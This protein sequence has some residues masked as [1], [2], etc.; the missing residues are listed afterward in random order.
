[1][2]PNRI[3]SAGTAADRSTQPKLQRPAKLLPNPML[4]AVVFGKLRPIPF[5]MPM[6]QAI[7][8]GRKT[9]TR[10]TKGFAGVTNIYGMSEDKT[11]VIADFTTVGIEIK[12]SRLL[13]PYQIGDILWVRETWQKRS[14]KALAMGFEKYFY[15]AGWEGCT[16]A[17]WKPSIFMPK[18]ACRIFLKIK[19][20]RAEKLQNI[21]EADAKAEGTI[22]PYPFDDNA[23]HKIAFY[24]LWKD[25]NGLESLGNNPFVWVIEFE[26]CVHP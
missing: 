22:L 14:E 4:P 25:I 13:C 18:D 12:K 1:M 3:T 9:Q 24:N 26:R 5:S 15:K 2:K 17:G 23:T 6:V 19:N 10:R 8:E 7:L 16:D 11:C 21:S 20:I